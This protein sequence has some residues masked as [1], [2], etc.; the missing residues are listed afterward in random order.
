MRYP[1][2][3]CF[4]CGFALLLA[5][6]VWPSS[7]PLKGLDDEMMQSHAPFWLASPEAGAAI[8]INN[9]APQGAAFTLRLHGPDGALLDSQEHF[10]DSAASLTIPLSDFSEGPLEA[11]YAVLEYPA[12]FRGR[13][14]AQMVVSSAE[15]SVS[16]NYLFQEK[17]NALNPEMHWAF[18]IPSAQSDVYLMLLNR[19]DEPIDAKVISRVGARESAHELQIAPG[20]M[21]RLRLGES[22]G[23]SLR[24]GAAGGI[25]LSHSGSSGDLLAEGFVLDPRRGISYTLDRFDFDSAGSANLVFPLLRYGTM[26]M[27]RHEAV[28]RPLAVLSNGSPSPMEVQPLVRLDGGEAVH[29]DAWILQPLESKAVD[30][31]RLL[32]RQL[33]SLTS[34]EGTLELAHSGE[35]GDLAATVLSSDAQSDR[36]Y[37]S[38]VKQEDRLALGYSYPFRLSQGWNTRIYLTNRTA[39]PV[40]M[41]VFLHF[42]GQSYTWSGTKEL[43]PFESRSVDIGQ[44]RDEQVPDEFGTVIPLETASGQ[45]IVV[46]HD[47]DPASVA[48]QAVIENEEA[49]LVLPA[50]CSVCPPSDIKLYLRKNRF[51]P[52]FTMASYVGFP[53]QKERI[54]AVVRNS[55]GGEKDISFFASY[56]SSD[57]GIAKVEKSFGKAEVKFLQPGFAEEI[58]ATFSGCFY[59]E[60]LGEC[61]GFFEEGECECFCQSVPLS[62]PEG[63]A[64]GGAN[65][66]AEALVLQP[67]LLSLS[68]DRHVIGGSTSVTLQG[69][70]FVAPVTV[71][72]SGSGITATVQSVTS[73]SITATFSL[74]GSATAGTHFVTVTSAGIATQPRAFVAQRPTSLHVFSVS[75][76]PTGTSTSASGCT[77]DLDFGIKVN[78]RY[79]VRDQEDDPI[80]S[81]DMRPQEIVT[82]FTVNGSPPS[83]P[84]PDWEDIGPSRISGTS[85]MTD[86][87]GRFRDAPLGIC[88]DTTFMGSFRQRISVLVGGSRFALRDHTIT[89]ESMAEGHGEIS[90]GSDLQRSR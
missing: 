16:A 76:L 81:D 4:P 40:V 88:G 17:R 68:P 79:E 74:S 14:P 13:L 78:V 39:K 59:E 56:S 31:H 20:A 50:A 48:T 9:A 72:V 6:V 62:V 42:D 70:G 71:N 33:P 61:G 67:T 36:I 51:D 65:P 80:L 87:T 57:P 60:P 43:A 54:Y 24:P 5:L 82:S 58:G 77:P 15:E 49:G 73:T 63:G 30:L 38:A 86:A 37:Q 46:V 25:R 83:N 69:Q 7:N 23:A 26:P 64:F 19:S 90:N 32:R 2:W 29:L 53:G 84:V 3:L 89:V 27:G 28:F 21:Q 11:G 66:A 22:L 75:T 44:L 12:A 85:Q 1:R 41:C 55:L 18:W 8:L 45:A 35:P 47:E 10:I 34:F 52:E